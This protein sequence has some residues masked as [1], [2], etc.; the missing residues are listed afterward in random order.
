MQYEDLIDGEIYHVL[1]P[2][3][4]VYIF[5]A[6]KGEYVNNI[7]VNRK[8]YWH[9]SGNMSKACHKLREYR[10]A[11]EEEKEHFLQCQKAKRYKDYVSTK[12]IPLIFN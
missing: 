11:T 7:D 9:E 4:Q 10:I 8:D 12:F 3:N 5:K 2:A 1:Y 6:K